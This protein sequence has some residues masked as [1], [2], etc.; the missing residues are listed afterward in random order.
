MR[1]RRR[2]AW[3][4]AAAAGAAS[5]AAVGSVAAGAPGPARPRVARAAAKVRTV[6]VN[7]NYYLPGKLTVHAG[8][9]VR[10]RWSLDATDVHDV[11][12]QRGP[13]GARRFQSD[14]L[15]AGDTFKRKLT[16][17]GTYRIICT[18]HESEMKM[19]IT[20]RKALR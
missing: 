15:A 12:L 2:L 8:D 16:K 6:T 18:F 5:L 11:E 20:V 9:T 7:D 13:A 19:T 10:W 17:P 14:P 3:V 4:V 1:A